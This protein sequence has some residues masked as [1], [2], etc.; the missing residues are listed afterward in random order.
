VVVTCYKVEMKQPVVRLRNRRV[1]ETK[2]LRAL[3]ILLVVVLTGAPVS[4][5]RVFVDHDR[6]MDRAAYAT[7]D[8]APTPETSLEDID[9]VLHSQVKNAIEF[10]LSPG[11][12]AEV[13]EGMPDLLVT[14]HTGV[15]GLVRLD[16]ASYGYD[17]GPDWTW[18]PAWGDAAGDFETKVKTYPRGTLIIDIWDLKAE[19]VVWRGTVVGLVP[20][21]P[22]TAADEIHSA[23]RAMVDRWREMYRE[24]AAEH[25]D[26]GRVLE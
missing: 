12:L 3:G 21:D 15:A 22:G 10:Y 1:V 26:L 17:Y 25:Q 6:G 7:F 23:L 19:R 9:P 8:W 13:D 14:Y 18:D 16:A 20:E 24:G 5:Q 4:A 11:G 2:M